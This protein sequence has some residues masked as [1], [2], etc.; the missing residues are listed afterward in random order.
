MNRSSFLKRCL[1]G[2][3]ALLA[4]SAKAN[5]FTFADLAFMARA[6]RAKQTIVPVNALRLTGTGTQVFTSA[7]C[8]SSSGFYAVRDATGAIQ[9]AASGSGFTV[10]AVGNYIDLWSCVSL[11]DA[12]ESGLMTEVSV[13]EN[14]LTAVDASVATGLTYLDVYGNSLTSLNVAN[15]SSLVTLY[16]YTNS[17]TS[18]TLNVTALNDFDA[19]GNALSS[20]AV[21]GLLVALAAGSV[22]SGTCSLDGGTNAA[23]GATGLAAKTTLEGRG[24][25]VTVT[26]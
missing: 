10:S 12:H 2:G 5:V 25:T 7:T 21:D 9:T 17:L 16:C 14:T 26:P 11:A 4:A 15:C 13:G 24:W 6:K 1:A 8:S 23:P 19:S 18:I 3:A 22:S 20:G